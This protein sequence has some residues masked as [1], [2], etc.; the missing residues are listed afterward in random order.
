MQKKQ[1]Q[2]HKIKL[3]IIQPNTFKQKSFL[4]TKLLQERKNL[5]GLQDILTTVQYKELERQPHKR[6]HNN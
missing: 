2:P 1:L 5:F 3:P 6:Y 4:F